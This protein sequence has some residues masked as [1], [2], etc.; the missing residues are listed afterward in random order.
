[1]D[2]RV[3]NKRLRTER[4]VWGGG[5]ISYN[6]RLRRCNRLI[7]GFLLY[8][9]NKMFSRL[10]RTW[11]GSGEVVFVVFG[12]TSVGAGAGVVGFIFSSTESN[13]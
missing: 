2:S 4:M 3:G 12:S 5:E 8:V 13:S 7:L 10:A 6:R 11:F 1:M 9:L